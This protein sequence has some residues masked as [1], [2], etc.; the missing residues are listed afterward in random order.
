MAKAL[1]VKK[2]ARGGRALGKVGDYRAELAKYAKEDSSRLPSSAGN[3]ISIRGKNFSYQGAVLEEPLKV[4]VIDYGFE[5][6]LYEGKWDPEDPQPPVC[7][8]VAKTTDELAPHPDSPKP[9]SEQCKGCPHNEYGTADTGKGKACKNSLRLALLSTETKKFDADFV[10]KTEP[11]L[12]RLP[13]TSVKHFR[14]YLKKITDGLQLPIFSVITA[15]SFEEEPA[16]PVV[17]PQFEEELDDRALIQALV[18][19]RES[20]QDAL[21]QPFDVSNYSEQAAKPKKAKPGKP[22]PKISGTARKAKF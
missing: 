2:P 3:Y 14:G 22:K 20:V 6:A 12:M 8:A 18:Q 4:A 13:P 11:A 1:A 17:V 21:L 10:A 16:T 7:F 15:L 5:N 9:Q 19:K